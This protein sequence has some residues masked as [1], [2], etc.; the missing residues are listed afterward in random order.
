MGSSSDLGGRRPGTCGSHV[1]G[2][3]CLQPLYIVVI[4]FLI[5]VPLLIP[6]Q[7][8]YYIHC[9]PVCVC[10]VLTLRGEK[11]TTP[12]WEGI[13]M[14]FLRFSLVG[15][16]VKNLPSM[17]ETQ[18]QSLGWGDFL[19]KGM[20]SPS[21]ISTCRTLCSDEPGGLQ[22]MGSQIVGHN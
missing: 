16:M 15:Q 17:Q 4:T 14:S 20:A 22:T 21:S 3:Q 5:S 11:K 19:E 2:R 8:L 7:S 6:P 18:V 1:S 12:T 10:G 9:A 13:G